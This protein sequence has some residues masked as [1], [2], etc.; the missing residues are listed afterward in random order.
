MQR[1]STRERVEPFLTKDGSIVRELMHPNA[2][3][4]KAQSLAEAIV[5]P[6]HG[7]ILHEHDLT[8]EVYHFTAGAGIMRLGQ[9]RFDVGAGD[10]VAILPGTPHK[11]ENGH[12]APL[13]LLCAC[14]PAYSH[15]DTRLLEPEPTETELQAR[16]EARLGAHLRTLGMDA[17][18]RVF[19]ASCHSVEDAAMAWGAPV[20]RFV[21]SIGMMDG[22]KLIV[23]VVKGEDRASREHVTQA[24]GLSRAPRLAKPWELLALTGYPA[25]GTPPLGYPARFVFD[26]RVLDE[27]RVIGGGGSPRALLA[28]DPR[29][30]VK[31]TGA[32]VGRIR[33]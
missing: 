3:A 15:E 10:T 29:A 8:E 27:E 13:V 7:T 6:G 24:L 19:D 5:P 30:I 14:A 9:E 25:G 11:L 22:E 33:A 2:H 32:E 16:R 1:R 12:D 21:K 23:A 4:V 17:E 28:L 31:A 20:E 26:E 18:H